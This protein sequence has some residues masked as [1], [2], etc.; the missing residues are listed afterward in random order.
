VVLF[1][2]AVLFTRIPKPASSAQARPSP[3]AI[4]DRAPFAA[5][6]GYLDANLRWRLQDDIGHPPPGVPQTRKERRTLLGSSGRA[7][8]WRGAIRLGRQRPL[9]GFGFGTERDVFADRYVGFNSGVPENSYIGIFLQLG[10]AGLACLLA[11][12]V[13]LLLRTRRALGVRDG[14]RRRTAAACAAVLVAGLVLG[15]FQSYLYAVGNN[16]T[17]ALWICAFLV[18]AAAAPTHV[19]ARTG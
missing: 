12:P 10:L 8:A 6:P 18:T 14:R 11:L 16:A 7:E 2:A 3:S 5:A 1:L 13:A 9:V 15:M 19:A 4:P 17:A